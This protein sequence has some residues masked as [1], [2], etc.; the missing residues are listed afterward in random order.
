MSQN[1]NYI[2]SPDFQIVQSRAIR[3]EVKK[4]KRKY[5]VLLT[6]L[7]L[8][9]LLAGSKKKRGDKGIGR[10]QNAFILY[11]KDLQAKLKIEGQKLTNA[12]ISR[13]ASAKWRKESNTIKNFFTVLAQSATRIH[14]K[15]FPGYRFHPNASRKANKKG[16]NQLDH[17]NTLAST[18]AEVESYELSPTFNEK[19]LSMDTD[20]DDDVT[21]DNEFS[22]IV[23]MDLIQ[24]PPTD[25]SSSSD[26]TLSS[27]ASPS[28]NS[29]PSNDVTYDGSPT[30]DF[31]LTDDIPSINTS[32]MNSIFI[33][34]DL[35]S[36]IVS[37]MNNMFITDDISSSNVSPTSDFFLTNE[38]SSS[39][40]SPTID[41]PLTN[42]IFL[43][44]DTYSSDYLL[45]P[46]LSS[47]TVPTMETDVPCD[48]YANNGNSHSIFG[49][50]EPLFNF[51]TD[52]D[53]YR[54]E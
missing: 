31:F 54:F 7:S 34:D 35:T 47:T 30:N 14:R 49:E 37:P 43:T 26:A 20:A 33:T 50:L 53:D 22:E 6:T 36:S 27:D 5:G 3:Q 28:I 25:I 18:S 13:I 45:F 2:D 1:S 48:E 4:L 15:L 17:N 38:I 40:V 11:R 46:E 12:E 8:E 10:E 41:I 23:F 32:P 24:Y 19:V 9:E 42:D 21:S 44:D 52:S 51:T 16:K 39:N 29:T